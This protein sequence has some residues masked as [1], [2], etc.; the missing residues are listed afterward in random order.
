MG[1][2]PSDYKGDCRPV[3]NVSYDMIRGTGAQA[4]SGWPK[5]GHAVDATSFMGRLQEKTGLTFDLPTEA[6]WEYACRAGTAT[7][8]N[9]GNSL[10]STSLYDAIMDETGRYYGNQSKGKGGYTSKHTKVGSYLANDWGLYD[11]HGNVSEWC[12]DWFSSIGT[13]AKTDPVGS[14][15]GSYRMIRGGSWGDDASYCRSAY[16]SAYYP[17]DGSYYFGFRV[18]CQP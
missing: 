1:R 4:G 15:T 14:T 7:A 16:R 10:T 8:F 18:L 12:L 11:M 17:S 6:Q 2:N 3:D 5:Y 9:S 13:A